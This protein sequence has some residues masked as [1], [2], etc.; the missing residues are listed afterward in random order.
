MKKYL[1][2]MLVP[3]LLLTMLTG[4][5]A[6][7]TDGSFSISPYLGGY[8]FFGEE[9]LKTRSVIGV[10]AGYNF[11]SHFGVEAASGYIRTEEK[12]GGGDVDALNYHLDMLYH[13]MPEGPLVPYLAAGYGG[14]WREYPGG[15]DFSDGAFNYGAGL[16]YFL[17]EGMALRGDVRHFVMKDDDETFHNLEYSVGVDFLF[18]QQKP[19]VAAVR[20]EQPQEEAPVEV[21]A[22]EPAPGHYK[23]C[24]TL[25]GEFDI[26]R[27]T[28]RPENRDE[29]AQVGEFMKKYPTT[30]AVIEGHTDNVGAADYNMELSRRRAEAVVD[31]LVENYGID[32]SRLAARGYGMSRPI[33]DNATDEGKQLNRRIE[34]IIDCVF[35]VKEIPPPDR[36]CAALMVEFDTGKSDIRPQYS[37]EIDKVGEYMKRYPTTTAIIEGHTDNVGAYDY[38][39]K[40]S[41]ER[42]ENVVN[43]LVQNFGID[44]SRLAAK[45]YGYT[46]RIA[47]NS[48]AEGRAKNRRINAVIDCV[49]KK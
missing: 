23:Y 4:A 41:L 49:V 32:R 36:L 18:G 30:T 1:L 17:T 6:G 42:A 21:P 48:T 27:A 34:A 9:H 14:H 2:L 40:L 15:R 5:D 11:T 47:Y 20:A 19:A 3:A 22:A 37:G 38:N 13:F 12:R 8:S 7:V 39:M 16:K 44:R 35:E 29:I 46:R 43:Y 24:I 25:Q 31:H 33:A 45:G 26:D 28:I 10:R